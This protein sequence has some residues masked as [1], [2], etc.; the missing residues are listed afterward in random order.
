M[1][2]DTKLYTGSG[3]KV[4]HLSEIATSRAHRIDAS[5]CGLSNALPISKSEPYIAL[6][7]LTC[8]PIQASNSKPL[9]LKNREVS[10]GGS[11][12]SEQDGTVYGGRMW[13]GQHHTPKMNIFPT[14][15]LRKPYGNPTEL[16]DFKHPMS[17]QAYLCV[18]GVNL[19]VHI[20]IRHRASATMWSASGGLAVQGRS[21]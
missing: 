8:P 10:V 16:Q 21:C 17:L 19:T 13:Q 14:A 18:M 11:Q 15:T 1:R 9:N 2:I 20:Y 5:A 7:C 4:D 12:E 3:M 6:T